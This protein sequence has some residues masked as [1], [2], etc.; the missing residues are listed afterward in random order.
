[1]KTAFVIKVENDLTCSE[2]HVECVPKVFTSYCHARN[3]LIAAGFRYDPEDTSEGPTY[4]Y[5]PGD[6]Y[7]EDIFVNVG[8]LPFDLEMS[9]IEKL[10]ARIHMFEVV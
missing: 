3:A 10:K 9:C 1:M 7:E 8:E 2:H 6:V 5:F 4:T